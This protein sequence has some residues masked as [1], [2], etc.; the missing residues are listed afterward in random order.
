ME[1]SVE[2]FA[3]LCAQRDGGEIT[4]LFVVGGCRSGKTRLAMDWVSA[5]RAPFVYVATCA[6]WEDD[7]DM[8]ARV[9]RHQAERGPE[10]VTQEEARNPVA[11]LHQ[12]AGQ[13][14]GAAIVDCVTV[15]ISNLMMAEKSD[16]EILGA[17][18]C[19]AELLKE[20]PLPVAIVSGEAGMGVVPAT[21]LG[22]RFRDIQG[23][24]NQ[25]LAAA[26]PNVVMAVCGLPLLIK[27]R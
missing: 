12:A 11:A 13:G 22:R 7:G 1:T 14:A 8:S 26:C 10:W 19:L 23:E 21:A 18:R 17:V 16:I 15:W 4:S 24:A 3:K 20:P 2:N 25:I 9:A 5:G 6:L 27:G